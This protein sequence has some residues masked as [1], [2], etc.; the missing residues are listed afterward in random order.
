MNV[1]FAIVLGVLAMI[2]VPSSFA[3]PSD[4]LKRKFDQADQKIIRLPPSAFPQLPGNILQELQRRG[5]T[6]P[7]STRKPQNVVIGNFDRTPGQLDWAILCSVNRVSSILVFFNGSEKNVHEVARAADR[8][9]LVRN[10]ADQI[11]YSRGIYPVGKDF[12]K[13]HDSAYSD[14][15]PPTFDHQGIEDALH[16]KA[17]VIVTYYFYQGNWLKLTGAD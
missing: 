4:D 12:I 11:V 6:I 16:G 10:M 1:H 2:G 14:P 3:Q 9:Y 8:D 7:Q 15:K 13:G 5:C 17:P